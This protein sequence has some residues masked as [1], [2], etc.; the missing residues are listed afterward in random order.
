MRK[1]VLIF[2]LSLI[3]Y[4]TY[5][6]VEKVLCIQMKDGSKVSFFLNEKPHTTFVADSVEVISATAQAKIKRTDVQS[7]K[8]ETEQENG[9]DNI[10]NPVYDI[11]GGAV[12]VSGVKPGSN[13]RIL[14]IDGRTAMSV[15]AVDGT[16]LFSIGSLP[17]GIY[18]LNYNDTTIKFV[19][20]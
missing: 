5:A 3:S 13:V 8:F 6:Q 1:T 19:K 4:L 14:T 15:K 17:A 12:S 2:L 10:E 16:A 7:F 18:L 11:T 20:P 9:I